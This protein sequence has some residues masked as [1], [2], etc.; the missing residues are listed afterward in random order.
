M[1]KETA[2]LGAHIAAG[3]IWFAAV[4]DDGQLVADSTD[5]LELADLPNGRGLSELEESIEAALNRMDPGSVV[6]LDAG[7]SQRPPSSSTVRKRAWLE[8]ALM[9]AS[10][11]TNRTVSTISHASVKS[12]LGV[13]PTGPDFKEQMA[14]QLDGARPPRW[15]DRAPAF[16]AGLAKLQR[17]KK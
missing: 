13:G 5:R 8:S 2:V 4:S 3:V 15:S 7:S 17:D 11:R 6:L 10:A 16:G 14:H 1:S 12:L 9:I